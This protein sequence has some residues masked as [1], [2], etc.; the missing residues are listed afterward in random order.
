MQKATLGL[1]GIIVGLLVAFL[2][3]GLGLPFAQAQTAPDASYAEERA[4][5]ENLQ[6]RY[7]FALDFKDHDLY[8]TTFTPDGILDVGNGEVVGREAIK[9]AVANMPGGRHHITNLVLRIDGDTATGRASWLHTGTN[10]EGRMTIGGYGHYEDDLVKVD[11]E[12]L[13]A[14]RRIYN[15]GNEAWAAPPGNPAW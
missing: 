5:I 2:V 12:W 15:E 3:S 7:L 9:A 4:L 8:V 14:K 1:T 10:A 6:A 11:G 13:F